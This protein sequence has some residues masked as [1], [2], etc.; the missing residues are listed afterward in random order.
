M[1]PLALEDIDEKPQT[2]HIAPGTV[3]RLG[4]PNRIPPGFSCSSPP[5][6]VQGETKH[7]LFANGATALTFL[8]EQQL[9]NFVSDWRAVGANAMVRV[10]GYASTPGSDE[11]NGRLSCQRAKVVA[12]AFNSPA[13]AM[14][15]IPNGSIESCMARE[16]SEFGAE[17]SNCRA[18][19]YMV[20]STAPL[21]HRLGAEL[22]RKIT[23]YKPP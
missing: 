15:G 9:D 11:L 13:R 4:D 16:T 3:Q 2:K 20:S 10:D 22:C 23:F 6:Q 12:N 18:W 21:R 1:Q 17:A 5:P 19:I 7:V 8:L 14:P